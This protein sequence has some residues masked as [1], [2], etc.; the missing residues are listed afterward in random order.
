MSLDAVLPLAL[1]MALVLSFALHGLAASGHFPKERRSAALGAGA[2][3]LILFGSLI[4]SLLA[5]AAGLALGTGMIPWYAAVIGCGAMVLAA[6]LLLQVFPDNVVD[7][8]T[9]LI[10][11]AGVNAVAAAA[12]LGL[13]ER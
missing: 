7:G 5:L 12:L 11:L 3:P 9:V 4:V 10:V 8:R 2:G 1:L 6:P 13:T